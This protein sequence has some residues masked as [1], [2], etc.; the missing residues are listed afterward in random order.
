VK[1]ENKSDLTTS[2]LA[3]SILS[4]RDT[5]SSTSSYANMDDPEHARLEKKRERNREAAR[6][7]RT[8]KLEKIAT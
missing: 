3:N 2:E 1:K 5:D 8:R 6:K 7:C 4:R